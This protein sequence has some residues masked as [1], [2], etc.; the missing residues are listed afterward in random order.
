M[1]NVLEFSD[2]IKEDKVFNLEE[3]FKASTLFN[4][5][6]FN[7]FI[8]KVLA[9][10]F[11][12]L[13]HIAVFL[14]V[15]YSTAYTI[16]RNIGRLA[17]PLFIFTTVESVYKTKREI[18]Y[19]ITLFVEAFFYTIVVTILMYTPILKNQIGANIYIG[20]IF[21]DLFLGALIAFFVKKK[22]IK[23]FYALI[24]FALFLISCFEIRVNNVY[25]IPIY[26]E[27]TF[28]SLSLF[29][30]TIISYFVTPII[31]EKQA[32]NNNLDKELYIKYNYEKFR[33]V[34]LVILA[35]TLFITNYLLNTY[36]YYI[37]INQMED[38]IFY[39]YGF[40]SYIFILFYNGQRGFY[41]KYVKY[42]FHV[43]YPAHIL[44]FFLFG[45]I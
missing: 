18:R 16:L 25:V 45:L 2:E 7:V 5:K 9:L 41:N 1:Q 13:D 19:L 42:A 30:V 17:L 12:T 31:L 33:N 32:T 27:Y 3:E 29:V 38:R 20:N 39:D 8:L 37:F 10:V 11:M 26:T 15:P 44:T 28:L 24:P 34:I 6:G 43:Y 14:L 21:V 4:L 35:F 23:S 40:I 22:S 36:G